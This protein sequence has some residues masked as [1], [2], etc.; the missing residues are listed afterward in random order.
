MATHAADAGVLRASPATA[1]IQVPGNRSKP[2]EFQ[3]MSAP[4][5]QAKTPVLSLGAP[6]NA[7]GAFSRWTAAWTFDPESL[8]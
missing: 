1:G 8:R 6:A 2:R 4:N 3:A 5:G 7:V